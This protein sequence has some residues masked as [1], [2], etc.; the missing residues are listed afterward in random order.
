MT[1]LATLIKH[2]FVMDRQTYGHS[3]YSISIQSRG[4]KIIIKKIYLWHVIKT[5]YTTIP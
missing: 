5:N 3:I 2:Q 4:K 1:S